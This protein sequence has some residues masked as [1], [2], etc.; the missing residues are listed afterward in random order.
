MQESFKAGVQ[1]NFSNE[2]HR[3]NVDILRP[4]GEGLLGYGLA[5][6]F[7][8]FKSSG[9]ELHASQTHNLSKQL[10]MRW[11]TVFKVK[12]RCFRYTVQGDTSGCYQT[13][14]SKSM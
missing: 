13:L 10:V 8:T 2:G 4:W 12:K 6:D 3:L 5:K 7:S 11:D 9:V 14:D 1:K